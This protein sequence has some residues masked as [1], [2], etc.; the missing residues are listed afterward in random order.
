MDEDGNDEKLVE[1]AAREIVD[2]HGPEAIP[3]LRERAEAADMIG[4]ELAAETWRDIAESA[5]RLLR[6]T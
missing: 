2:Q 1:K 6:Q 3:I 5:E 4:D